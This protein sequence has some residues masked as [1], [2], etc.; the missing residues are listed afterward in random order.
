MPE[1]PERKFEAGVSDERARAIRYVDKKWVNGTIL[2]YY[3]FTIGNNAGAKR[4]VDLVREAFDIW[5]DVGIGLQFQEVDEITDAEV[6]IG[7]RKGDGAWSYVGRDVIDIP[8][9][10][11]RTMNFGWDLTRDPRG[12]DTPVHEIGHTLGYPHEHQNPFSGIVWNEQK[13]LDY[14]A[15]APNNWSGASTR[16]NVLRKLPPSSVEGSIWDPDSVMHYDF[17]PGMIK[18]PKRYQ[19]GLRPKLG[20]S[21]LD[22]KQVR[23]FYPPI[24]DDNNDELVPFAT[25]MLSLEPAGQRN[26]TIRPTETREY[27]IQTFGQSDTVMVLFENDNGDLKYLAGD[28]DSGS[29]RNAS[30][31]QWLDKSKTYTLRIRL[32]SNHASGDTAVMVW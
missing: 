10:Q 3:F 8:G 9:Q 28:D 31:S 6:R 13:V 29:S 22:K 18:K 26:Y 14:F 20:L 23:L 25:S 21:E 12:L 32:Y 4:Q 7:F 15:G 17:G 24:N 16:R 2:H 11:E 19:N 30:L 1:V 27:S 5:R